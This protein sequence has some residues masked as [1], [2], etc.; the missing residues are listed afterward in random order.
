MAVRTNVEVYGTGFVLAHYQIDSQGRSL[1]IDKERDD[2]G[3]VLIFSREIDA[4]THP[5]R[6]EG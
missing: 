3:N 2:N 5:A 1:Y 6:K 4:L